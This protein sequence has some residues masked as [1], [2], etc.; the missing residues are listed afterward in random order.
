MADYKLTTGGVLRASD[1]AFIPNDPKNKDWLAYQDWLAV[2]NTPD[3]ADV[4]SLSP[5]KAAKV[6]AVNLEAESRRQTLSPYTLGDLLRYREAA[7]AVAD[8]TPTGAE[9]PML[10]AERVALS[11]TLATR[12]T[13]VAAEE[14]A[15]RTAIAAVDGARVAGIAAI[16][17]AGSLA[18]V[19]AAVAAIAW[20]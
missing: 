7:A 20:P 8:G 3:P 19:D 12:A 16:N 11:V 2:P 18:A 6:K 1:K 15:V 17:A 14:L 5:Y 13:A 4:A 9:Y 10:E